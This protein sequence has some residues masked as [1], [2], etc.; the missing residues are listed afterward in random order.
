[1]A[2]QQTLALESVREPGRPGSVDTQH[3]GQTF[4]AT[5]ATGEID[6][7]RSLLGGH[8]VCSELAVQQS[9]QLSRGIVQQ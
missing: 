9:R 6:Q 3:S 7:Q 2:T 5:L 1:M 4:R 8:S